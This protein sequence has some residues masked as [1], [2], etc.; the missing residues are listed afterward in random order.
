MFR[1]RF[2]HCVAVLGDVLYVMGGLDEYIFPLKTAER[3][4]AKADRWSTIADMN[5]WRNAASATA[6]NGNMTI[7]KQ[8]GIRTKCVAKCVHNV[9]VM[10]VNMPTF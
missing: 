8:E 5:V 4:D 3:Y 6:L 9:E 10:S 1:S 2:Y 7:M